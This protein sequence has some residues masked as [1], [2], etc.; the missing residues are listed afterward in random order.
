[1][2]RVQWR[3]NGQT[4]SAWRDDATLAQKLVVALQERGIAPAVKRF[5]DKEMADLR[6]ECDERD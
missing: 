6:K 4:H 3:E 5:S 1:M 2:I